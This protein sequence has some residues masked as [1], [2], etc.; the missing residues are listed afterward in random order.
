MRSREYENRKK[1]R[2]GQIKDTSR[3]VMNSLHS[4]NRPSQV[5]LE[6]EPVDNPAT[7]GLTRQD[8]C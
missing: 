4:H 7:R 8:G 6:K 5:P 1:I 2:P 3:Y